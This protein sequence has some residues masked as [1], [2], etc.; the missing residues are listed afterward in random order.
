MGR[1]KQ[2]GREG[3]IYRQENEGTSQ[4]I[5]LAANGQIL[6]DGVVHNG[7]FGSKHATTTTFGLRGADGVADSM[8]CA[9]FCFTGIS[10][11]RSCTPL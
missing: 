4:R 9:N 5:L 6:R 11:T 1:A 2:S 10:S 8:D 7:G 3:Y